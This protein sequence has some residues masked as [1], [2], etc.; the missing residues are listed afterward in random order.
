MKTIIERLDSR[1]YYYFNLEKNNI[2]FSRNSSGQAKNNTINIILPFRKN[3][4]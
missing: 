2:A 1:I 3:R 4:T